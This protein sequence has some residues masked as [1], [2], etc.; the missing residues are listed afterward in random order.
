[1]R[2]T[3]ILFALLSKSFNF[4]NWSLSAYYGNI[5]YIDNL[6]VDDMILNLLFHFM[7][8][9]LGYFLFYG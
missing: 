4:N 3:K 1:M 2:P 9:L 5:F 8:L 7:G 6:N